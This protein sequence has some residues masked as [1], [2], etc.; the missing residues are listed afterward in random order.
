[1]V[2]HGLAAT[3]Y[4]FVA[5]NPLMFWD[6]DRAGPGAP[7]PDNFFSS[8]M[9][10]VTSWFYDEAPGIYVDTVASIPVPFYSCL[11]HGDGVGCVVDLVGVGLLTRA[12]KVARTV[13]AAESVAMKLVNEVESMSNKT[14]SSKV[15]AP[16]EMTGRSVLRTSI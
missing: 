5:G 6:P 11:R 3:P 16:A 8:V 1:M 12:L 15:A 4:G 2:E 14:R 13:D 9:R 10:S 7:G